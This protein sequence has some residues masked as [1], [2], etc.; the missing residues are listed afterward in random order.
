MSMIDFKKDSADAIANFYVEKF[1]DQMEAYQESSMLSR[2]GS[3]ISPYEIIA[4][5]Q[6][7]DQF[8]NYREFTESQGNLAALGAIPSVALDVITASVGASILPLITSIQPIEEEHGIVWFKKIAAGQAAGGYTQGQTIRDPLSRDN[9]GDGTLGSQRRQE[10][11][12]TTASGTTS[13][14][15]TLATFPIRPFMLEVNIPGIGHGKDDGAGNI[16]GFGFSGEIN[17]ETGVWTIELAADPASADADVN[18]IYDLDVDALASIPKIEAGLTSK[19]IRAEI[20]ALSADTGSFANF[21]FGKRF[22]RSALDEVASDLQQEITNTLNV[23]AIKMLLANMVGNTDWNEKP[24]TGVSYAEHKLTFIDAIAD[25][26][27]VLHGN[28]G[29]NAINRIVAGKSAAARLRAMPEFVANPDASATSVSLFGTYDGV[30]VI[31]ATGVVDDAKAVLVSNPNNYFNAPIAYSPFMPL[32]VTNTVQSASNP[33]RNTT[34]V[35]IWAGMTALN[36]N[37]A[38]QL[39][40]T[41]Q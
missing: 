2:I 10:A 16:L 26:E 25:A 18:V 14:T 5:G 24:G 32:M 9:P 11:I 34:A 35:G 22:G 21:A 23:R 15:G 3:Q 4:M 41:N 36:G 17:Y 8:N 31:R 30:P 12:A 20:F 33:F 13:Y 37:L 27:A 6:M 40:I 38:T 7:L 28:S 29:Q 19:D 1:A 39:T